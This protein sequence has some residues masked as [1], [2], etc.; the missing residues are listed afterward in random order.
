MQG[1]V[2]AGQGRARQG[3]GTSWGK[4][5]VCR[6]VFPSLCLRRCHIISRT[7][8]VSRVQLVIADR[9]VSR[10]PRKAVPSLLVR[11][12][13]QH[14]ARQGRCKQPATTG[15]CSRDGRSEQFVLAKTTA[16]CIAAPCHSRAVLL[17]LAR[18]AQKRTLHPAQRT[19]AGHTP[20]LSFGLSRSP[21]ARDCSI[22]RE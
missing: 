7:A 17:V 21:A 15:G 12:T 13:R 2:Q 18:L 16:S 6:L 22:T 4:Q 11:D 1:N 20:S 14:T 9:L 10:R 3:K 19:G 5:P 8:A